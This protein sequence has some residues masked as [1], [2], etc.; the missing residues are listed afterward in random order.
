LYECDAL[1]IPDKKRNIRSLQLFSLMRNFYQYE[2]LE[3]FLYKKPTH[4]LNLREKDMM[5]TK[6]DLK[7]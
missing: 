1:S 6:E 2:K 5:V 7:T 3:A 4:I